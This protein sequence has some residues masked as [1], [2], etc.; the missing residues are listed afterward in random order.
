MGMKIVCQTI[1]VVHFSCADSDCSH[2]F[3]IYFQIQKGWLSMKQMKQILAL[4]LT[5][6][7]ILTSNV[8][9]SESANEADFSYEINAAFRSRDLIE[10]YVLLTGRPGTEGDIKT[11]CYLPIYY[12]NT[13]KLT[14]IFTIPISIEDAFS[15]G[16][17]ING[18]ILIPFKLRVTDPTI[19]NY[20][21]KAIM[22][23]PTENLH[24]RGKISSGFTNEILL[25]NI[26]YPIFVEFDTLI[27]KVSLQRNQTTLT[28]PILDHVYLWEGAIEKG[29]TEED[30]AVGENITLTDVDMNDF[31]DVQ[32][33]Y[34]RI[35][36][37]LSNDDGYK[38]QQIELLKNFNKT[39]AIAP[40]NLINAKNSN[41][42]AEYYA[43]DT[44]EEASYLPLAESVTVYKNY[45]IASFYDVVPGKSN[46]IN[47]Y[48]YV[49]TNMDG[50]YETVYI[51][52]EEVFVI[53]S[54]MLSSYRI[55]PDFDSMRT[56]NFSSLVLNP[57]DFYTNYDI[58]IPF[59]TLKP[60]QIVRVKQSED[61]GC[62]FYKVNV[63]DP[64]TVIGEVTNVVTT[65]EGI[66]YT[67]G[68]IDYRMLLDYGY[69]SM[70]VGDR[71]EIKGFNDV[72]VD[73]QFVFNA[74]V[75]II[76][77]SDIVDEFDTTYQIKLLNTDGKVVV[78]N[79][80]D[81]VN[82]YTP[83]YSTPSILQN[84]F[85]SGSIFTYYLG[86]NNEICTYDVQDS[87][88][89][90]TLNNGER[91]VSTI[92][93]FQQD[94]SKLGRYVITEETLLFAA[95]CAQEDVIQDSVI[96]IDA[97]ALKENTEY[98]FGVLY[99]VDRNAIAVILYEF[100]MDEADEDIPE[101]E[102]YTPDYPFVVTKTAVIT[103]DG[104]ERTKYF[105]YI[106]GEEMEF[107]LSND[108]DEE[109]SSLSV[110]DS[111]IISIGNDGI[112]TID[113]IVSAEIIIKKNENGFLVIDNAM[114]GAYDDTTQTITG[115]YVHLS[116]IDYGKIYT[117]SQASSA[118]S[119]MM[120]IGDTASFQGFSAA[121]KGYSFLGKL[122]RL[123][124]A[125]NYP[126]TF[127]SDERDYKD[128]MRIHDYYI[129]PNCASTYC[130]NAK[131][132]KI[133]VSNIYDME[134]DNNT[135][136]FRY[137]DQIENDDIVYV[138]NYDGET[139]FIFIIDVKG[140]NL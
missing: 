64:K 133:R 53:G 75:G 105:G 46:Y 139:K 124:N 129:D 65:S 24:P 43:S 14:D 86:D 7:M 112:N 97:S 116:T 56:F 18:H 138:Y 90:N 114:A 4:L 32:G 127:G 136:D 119:T 39:V 38:L 40:I 100:N 50:L 103:V 102:I 62:I 126:L 79:L 107:L 85:P 22:V 96:R 98:S 122:L 73:Y 15:Q 87:Y 2:T 11:I 117:V 123:V 48:R 19:A 81:I 30:F 51:D 94:V 17:G 134:T 72:I 89:D 37:D 63:Q 67:I 71:V 10:G 3:L 135:M 110:G 59:G 113:Q 120:T 60:G 101:K 128:D 58:N 55:I 69:P 45:G 8:M 52:C 84:S 78:Y 82:G 108:A 76:L 35:R 66:R 140:D 54:I 106:N 34:C 80:A 33:L 118:A 23:D 20:R 95:D 77:D 115:N 29:Y 83:N 47:E 121:G 27:K 6:L 42:Q 93:E 44:S 49:D 88:S 109:A 125:N 130:Y 21:L 41:N 57:E 70:E 13:S 28:I 137:G 99:D 92:G 131:T 36:I 74:N 31:F 12:E 25:S 91:I 132:D 9:A 111:A 104:E 1:R 26:Y 16:E 68:D 61:A 5:F